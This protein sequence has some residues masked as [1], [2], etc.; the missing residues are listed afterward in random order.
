[1]R[2]TTLVEIKK[3][4]EGL[5]GASRYRNGAWSI[6]NELAGAVSQVQVNCSTWEIEGSRTEANREGMTTDGVYTVK[7]RGIIVIGKLTELD[8]REKRNSFEQFRN[9]LH[10]PEIITYDELYERARFIVDGDTTSAT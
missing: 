3:P 7:P 9:N 8:D 10:N 1:M 6:S 4:Q 5:L 2:F